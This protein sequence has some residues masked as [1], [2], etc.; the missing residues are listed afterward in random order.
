MKK[1]L[2]PALAVTHAA[3]T[4]LV[5]LVSCE[6]VKD[7]LSSSRV[8]LK[9]GNPNAI[10]FEGLGYAL[11]VGTDPHVV[12]QTLRDTDENKKVKGNLSERF[13]PAHL[14]TVEN[15]YPNGRADSFRFVAV[16]LATDQV[17]FMRRIVGAQVPRSLIVVGSNEWHTG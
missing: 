13:L 16:K 11:V 6:D 14:T 2:V 8:K 17:S 1:S 15:T 4:T 9:I 12:W 10:E 7:Y 3:G 5:L